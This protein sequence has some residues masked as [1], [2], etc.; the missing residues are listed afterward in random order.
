[1]TIVH[2][3]STAPYRTRRRVVAMIVAIWVLMLAIN[4]PVLA[5]YRGVVDEVSGTPGCVSTSNSAFHPSGVLS[6]TCL[7][8][9]KTGCVHLCWV[10]VTLCDLIWQVTS[11]TVAVRWS[12]INSYTGPLNI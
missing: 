12:S 5:T 10:E 9:V 8:E 7:A 3:T 2:A 6:T 4:T 1:M 11:C